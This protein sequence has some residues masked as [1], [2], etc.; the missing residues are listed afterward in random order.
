[1]KA[2]YFITTER[3]CLLL[4][5]IRPNLKATKDKTFGGSGSKWKSRLWRTRR[6]SY[7]SRMYIMCLYMAYAV[8][9][10][11]IRIFQY[12]R[13]IL[14]VNSRIEHENTPSYTVFGILSTCQFFYRSGRFS[15]HEIDIG[16]LLF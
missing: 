11:E 6:E 8:L 9:M 13:L 15:L 16:I 10:M 12:R 3:R 2:K 4:P 7:I 14:L 1:M 5:E